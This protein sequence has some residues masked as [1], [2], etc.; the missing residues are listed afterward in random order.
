[1][2]SS[3][4]QVL[5]QKSPKDAWI[6]QCDFSTLEKVSGSYVADDLRDREDDLIWKI[7]WG[8]EW[9]YVY[10]LLE[11]QSSVNHFMAVRIGGTLYFFLSYSVLC[12]FLS[13]CNIMSTIVIS[14][15]SY[16]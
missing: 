5:S 13:T 8:D 1:M 11:F 6:E 3:S 10:L 4:G 15:V 7:R 16:A 2:D 12:S 14:G 9:L